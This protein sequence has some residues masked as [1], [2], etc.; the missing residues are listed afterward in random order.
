VRSKAVLSIAISLVLGCARE[1]PIN[2]PP[3]LQP[4]ECF[5]PYPEEVRAGLESLRDRRY[6]EADVHLRR[7]LSV[8]CFE[9]PNYGA[10]GPLTEAMCQGGRKEEGRQILSDY[11][12][13]LDIE[14][15][16][17]RCYEPEWPSRGD[18]LT[19]RCFEEMCSE[20]YA[21]TYGPTEFALNLMVQLDAPLQELGRICQ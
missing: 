2:W 8:A 19:D 13:M 10:N 1:E 7:A 4:G 17:K 12:C 3:A 16:A 18:G 11:R 14:V 5:S 6:A 20:M 21:S 9:T 15:G